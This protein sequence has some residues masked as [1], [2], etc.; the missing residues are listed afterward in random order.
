[1]SVHC[2]ATPSRRRAGRICSCT[3]YVQRT[4]SQPRKQPD[5]IDDGAAA[6]AA[7]SG[8]TGAAQHIGNRRGRRRVRR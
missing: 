8:V 1:M 2:T 6:A 5:V 7:W 4:P 3:L